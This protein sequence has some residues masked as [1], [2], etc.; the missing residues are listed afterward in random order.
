MIK[1]DFWNSP[2]IEYLYPDYFFYDNKIKGLR[3]AKVWVRE[4]HQYDYSKVKDKIK[5]LNYISN[6][7]YL[8]FVDAKYKS[9]LV[10]CE[11]EFN[12]LFFRSLIKEYFE[13]CFKVGKIIEKPLILKYPLVFKDSYSKGCW[14]DYGIDFYGPVVCCDFSNQL[15]NIKEFLGE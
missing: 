14:F 11:K 5:K 10:F 6:D 4:F 15:K 1:L 12:I 7:C 9:Y 8:A 13:N 3:S 2:V